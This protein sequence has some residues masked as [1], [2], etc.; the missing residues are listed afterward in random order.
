MEHKN[1]EQSLRLLILRDLSFCLTR[2][3]EWGNDKPLLSSN[4][5]V[6][7]FSTT[8]QSNRNEQEKDWIFLSLKGK[9][10]WNKIG[11]EGGTLNYTKSSV[12]IPSILL[13]EWKEELAS[14]LW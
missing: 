7:L 5:V 3:S 2:K 13:P 12:S 6:A 14:S 1:K 4:E 8:L 9:K 10:M 11:C